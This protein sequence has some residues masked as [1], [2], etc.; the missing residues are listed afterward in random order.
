MF[1]LF[2]EAG[3]PALKSTQK[4][5]TFFFQGHCGFSGTGEARLGSVGFAFLLGFPFEYLVGFVRSLRRSV[6]ISW[7]FLGPSMPVVELVHHDYVISFD[8]ISPVCVY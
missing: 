7:V 8:I 6:K 3:S 5:V 1:F 4:R 2:L